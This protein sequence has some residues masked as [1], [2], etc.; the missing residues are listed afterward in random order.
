MT[1]VELAR[2]FHDTYECLAPDFGYETRVDTRE[3]SPASKNGQLMTAVCA[4]VLTKLDAW[5]TPDNGSQP[6]AAPAEY[7]AP[8]RCAHCGE[9]KANCDEL[10][11][12]YGG[13]AGKCCPVC[14]HRAA[15]NSA[16]AQPESRPEY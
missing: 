2:F 11:T 9:S 12:A 16:A 13:E 3:F 14:D 10:R 5:S 7:L 6:T 1:P 4:E 15:D 8:L